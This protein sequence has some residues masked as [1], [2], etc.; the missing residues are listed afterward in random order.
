M[1]A[2]VQ[3]RS[4]HNTC[5]ICCDNTLRMYMPA[6]TYFDQL[7]QLMSQP[8]RRCRLRPADQSLMPVPTHWRQHRERSLLSINELVTALIVALVQLQEPSHQHCLQHLQWQIAQILQWQYFRN[9][10]WTSQAIH[11]IDYMWFV[12]T[13]CQVRS[14]PKC[15]FILFFF[16]IYNSWWIKIFITQTDSLYTICKCYFS[17]PI[18][19]LITIW[20][21]GWEIKKF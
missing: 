8:Q 13:S 2:E 1:N 3:Y 6:L 18:R 7:L 17:S 5:Y 10:A 19:S 4:I 21:F 20:L 12:S 16:C 15:V 14:L 9:I 11:L